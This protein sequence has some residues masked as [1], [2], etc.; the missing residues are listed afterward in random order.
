MDQDSRQKS[1]AVILY[2]NIREEES[3]RSQKCIR[4]IF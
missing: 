4:Q 1:V 3:E 2:A